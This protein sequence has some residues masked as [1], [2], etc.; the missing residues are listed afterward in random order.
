MSQ[1]STAP[2]SVSTA[3]E[4]RLSASVETLSGAVERWDTGYWSLYDLY[5]HRVRN[6]A[7]PFYHALHA[8]QLRLLAEMTGRSEL[9]ATAERFDSYCR[10]RRNRARALGE[11]VLFRLLVP[12]GRR[13]A[14]RA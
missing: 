5:R 1:R 4:K 8:R 10:R 7:S 13:G 12:H 14:V 6:V 3:A 9:E 11:K 2:A